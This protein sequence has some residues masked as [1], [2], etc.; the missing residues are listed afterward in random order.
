MDA[1]SFYLIPVFHR[2]SEIILKMMDENINMGRLSKRIAIL[3]GGLLLF[4]Y[5]SIVV[6]SNKITEQ[7]IMIG[8]HPYPVAIAVG[9]ID[10][11]L[12]QLRTLPERL[13]YTKTPGTI[14]RVK[15]HYKEIDNAISGHFDFILERYIYHPE[16]ARQLKELYLELAEKQN[17]LI[18][19][20]ESPEGTSEAIEAHYI[21]KIVPV[22]DEMNEITKS[23]IEGSQARFAEL[24]GLAV[25]TRKNMII[26]ISILMV[27]VT[28]ALLLYLRILS[29]KSRHEEKMRDALQK[30]LESAQNANAAKSQFLSNMSHDIRTPMNG[31]IGMTAI[32]SMHLDE[33]SKL[34]DCLGKIAASSKHLL[35]LINEVLDMSKI[36]SG[37]IAL[38][39]EEFLFPDLINSFLAI[40]QPQAKSKKLDLDINAGNIRHE[41]VVGDTLR[42]NQVLLNV[43]GNAIKFTPAGGRVSLKISELN[44][45]HSGYGAYQ[46]V[47][48]DTGIGMPREFLNKIYEPFERLQ[49]TTNSKIEGT[50]LGMA[51]A[52]SIIDMMNGSINIQSEEGKGTIVKIRLYLKLQDSNEEK[53][54]FSKLQELRSLVVDDDKDVC[55]DTVRLLNEIGMS[56]EWVLTGQEAVEK[57]QTAH[58]DDQDYQSIIVDWKM[59]EMNGLET[60]RRIRKIVGNDISIIILTAYDW[61]EIEEEAKEAGVDAFLA[62]PLFKSRLYHV[63]HDIVSGEKPVDETKVP[64]IKNALLTGRVLLA[65]DNQL[66]MEI[67]T[68]IIENSAALVEPAWDGI[69]AV[70][71]VAAA[72]EGYYSLVLMDIQMPNMDGYEA[73][74]QIRQL[75][76]EQGRVHVPI[77]AMSAN[78]FMD[79]ID[80][81]FA[82]GMDS[83]ITKPIDI[84][85]LQKKLG[86]F[87]QAK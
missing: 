66:N 11:G 26:L 60:T 44:E 19:L 24:E 81:A 1:V 4:I 50:G 25:R 77:I 7:V 40:V 16:E 23:V 12:A 10:T 65:E 76:Q 39:D 9:E 3:L 21:T 43:V 64:E 85:E 51:I 2:K 53:F 14:E 73:T 32:A 59:P 62:K 17:E 56:S 6:N 20:S 46:F 49:T 35:G 74:R 15:N 86:D 33:P 22:L 58:Q 63:M 61:T 84:R 45:Q 78:A 36:E 69:E 31:I 34:K 13:I 28:G 41:R 57:V 48:E 54:D 87:L 27:S 5:I 82:A 18:A 79:D 55:E 75:E 29:I 68:E 80:R 30:A 38:N 37:K 70:S 52:K 72:P 83:Y 67:A 47:I 42:I 71:K 8:E